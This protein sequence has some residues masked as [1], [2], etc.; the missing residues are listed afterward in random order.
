MCVSE[1]GGGGRVG[2]VVRTGE[3]GM[4]VERQRQREAETET[5][6]EREGQ[7][8]KLRYTQRQR[9]TP[10]IKRVLS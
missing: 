9:E 5:E 1:C 2:V 3:R 8:K 6:T 4:H 10:E 7:R